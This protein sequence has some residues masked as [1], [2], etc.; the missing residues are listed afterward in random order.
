MKRRG[1]TLVRG[2]SRLV[3]LGGILLLLASPI[4]A[5]AVAKQAPEPKDLNDLLNDLSAQIAASGLDRAATSSGASQLDNQHA[6]GS[7]EWLIDLATATTV[8]F[9]EEAPTPIFW[10]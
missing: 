9:N 10:K 5:I 2:V 6:V 8:N 3:Y 1:K 7:V 4:N